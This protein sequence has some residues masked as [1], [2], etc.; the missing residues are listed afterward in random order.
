MTELI[1]SM[2]LLCLMLC[3]GIYAIMQL[4]DR[5]DDLSEIETYLKQKRNEKSNH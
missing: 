2:F 3:G 5:A 4:D 1:L